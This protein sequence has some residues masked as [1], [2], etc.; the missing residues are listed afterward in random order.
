MNSDEAK[1]QLEIAKQ[2]LE[3]VLAAYDEPTDWSD[4]SIYGFYCLESAV[5]AAAIHLGLDIT[6]SHRGKVQTSTELSDSHGLPD[7]SDFLWELN[8]ARKAV[9]YGDMDF[10]DLNPEEVATKIENYVDEVAKLIEE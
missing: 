10:P 5:V 7:L 1:K 4:L 6:R 3:R 9:A 8:S 2:H